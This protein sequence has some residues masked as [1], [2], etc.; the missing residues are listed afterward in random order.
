MEDPIDKQTDLRHR[1]RESEAAREQLWNT[2]IQLDH[3][4]WS[5][6]LIENRLL[7]VTPNSDRILGQPAQ[8]FFEHPD[9]WKAFIHPED[10]AL[11][12][13]M[14]DHC[15]KGLPFD[16]MCRLSLPGGESRWLRIQGAPVE[17]QGQ[18][19]RVDG[20]ITDITREK[21]MEKRLRESELNLRQLAENLR[22]VVWLRTPQKMIYISPAYETIWGR[23]RDYLLVNPNAFIDSI[24]P[25]DRPRILQVLSS[26]FRQTG[27]FDEE[28]RILRPDGSIRW[29]WARSFPVFDEQGRIARTAG[30]AEDMT[31][32]RQAM[33]ALEEATEIAVRANRA[34]SEFLA[35]MS[36]EIRTP[37]NSI[38]GLT[39]LLLDTVL[40]ETQR[41]YTATLRSSTE[42]LLSILNDILDI[43]KIE[44][45][46]M[47][48]EI[49]DFNLA[50]SID[51]LVKMLAPRAKEK[52]LSFA[53]TLD[54][55]LRRLVRGDPL[56]LQQVL[57]NLIGNAIKFTDQGS[58]RVEAT[59][60]SE[61]DSSLTIYF[62]VCD[63][64]IGIDPD[65]LSTLFTPFSQADLSTTRRFGGTGLGLSISKRLV[66]MMGGHIGVE[67]AL[68]QG[69]TFWFSLPLKPSVRPTDL[70]RPVPCAALLSPAAP[71][72]A[73]AR[74]A[75]LPNLPILLAEDN[76]TNQK[77]IRLLLGRLGL[78]A[79]DIVSDGRQ[80]VE[81]ALSREYRLILMDFRMPAM[82]GL[83]ATRE[84]RRREREQCRRTTPIIALTAN[85][86]GDDREKCLAAGMND[87][88]TK[89]I[90]L[91]RFHR[92]LERYL[93]E[94]PA[95]SAHREVFD[96]FRQLST[97]LDPDDLQTLYHTFLQ[98]TPARLE[99]LKAAHDQGDLQELRFLAH[100]IKSGSGNLGACRLMGICAELEQLAK[101]ERLDGALQAKAGC[102]IQQADAEF[103]SLREAI[104]KFLPGGIGGHQ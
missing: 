21:S 99:A 70:A 33:V 38:L 32:R 85:A 46:R 42:I 88:L 41:D 71:Q 56:R 44:A 15:R 81:A 62:S 75:P 22:Q 73:P 6:D 16:Q 68:G 31:E 51:E 87:Y 78:T 58:V 101:K 40:D 96:K 74:Q 63:S 55:R 92:L 61:T 4:F 67:S 104:G 102:W 43:S 79:V 94:P 18:I 29:I 14:F 90:H 93:T 69:S 83:E 48:L 9:R 103:A 64:G 80:A 25:E 34:K 97:E 19:I 27:F 3:V 60:A 47:N 66:E 8:A 2:F 89:P 20:L 10:Q 100:Y 37:M 65:T 17:Q 7:Q 45:G 76:E 86:L 12:A 49:L 50:D 13:S 82:D 91:E 1:L 28:Y 36:H 98:D 57:F 30:I 77:L 11:F 5:F 72:V 39:E 54:P 53:V 84:I 26:S 23:S 52:G 59:V 24:H 35:V 95:E